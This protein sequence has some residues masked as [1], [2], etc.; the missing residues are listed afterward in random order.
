MG[1]SAIATA[2]II[3][4]LSSAYAATVPGQQGLRQVDTSSYTA[5]AE[6]DR[7]SDLP[8]LGKPEFGLFSG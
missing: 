8:G 2:G 7:I 6:A 5:E 1:R 4:W 3:L